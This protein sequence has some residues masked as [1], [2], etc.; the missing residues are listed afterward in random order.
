MSAIDVLEASLST[1]NVLLN[2]SIGAVVLGLIFEYA[3]DLSKRVHDI[4]PKFVPKLGAVLVILG[5]AG[6]LALHIK[7]GALETTIKDI[8]RTEII[9]L[10]TYLL[11]RSINEEQAKSIADK[12]G[13]PFQIE[14]AFSA[15]NEEEINLAIMLSE[16]AFSK[17]G[18]AWVD[19]PGALGELVTNLP[20]RRRIGTIPLSGVQVRILNSKL[21][22]VADKLVDA[23]RAVGLDNVRIDSADAPLLTANAR[24]LIEVMIGQKPRYQ[25]GK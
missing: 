19:W 11:P 13:S 6:E 15:T 12:I 1:L 18:W 8:Q 5:V 24:M 2:L 25:V 14:Y 17:V 22:G 9:S 23:L 16:K 20:G 7:S 4:I 3:P 21:S 10:E